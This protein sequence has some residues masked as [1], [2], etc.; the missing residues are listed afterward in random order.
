LSGDVRTVTVNVKDE[1]ARLERLMTT[2][3]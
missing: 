3:S 1:A 2:K